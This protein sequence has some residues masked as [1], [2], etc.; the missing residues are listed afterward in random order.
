MNLRAALLALI[1][2]LSCAAAAGE[3]QRLPWHLL[4]SNFSD[5][6]SEFLEIVYDR[7]YRDDQDNG[8]MDQRLLVIDQ[9]RRYVTLHT[10]DHVITEVYVSDNVYVTG[11]GIRI[12]DA[13]STVREAYPEAFRQVSGPDLYMGRF[14][15]SDDLGQI[16]FLFDND[17]IKRRW[18]QGELVRVEDE[19]VG[20]AELRMM[21]MTAK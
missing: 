1:W 15:V 20:R 19:S 21:H 4:G 6:K 14:Q 10:S 16:V 7:D 8:R 2:L 12:G 13:L 17:D 3:R 9:G 18:R 11:R 5:I